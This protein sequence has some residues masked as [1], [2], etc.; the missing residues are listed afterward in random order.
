MLRHGHGWLCIA[1]VLALVG[2]STP[3]H[4][5]SNVR[6]GTTLAAVA[7]CTGGI[8]EVAI[9]ASGGADFL[10]I[11]QFGAF[12]NDGLD[13]SQALERACSAAF[14][15]GRAVLIP[16]GVYEIGRDTA[17]TCTGDLHLTGQG[18]VQLRLDRSL[19]LT[20]DSADDTLVLAGDVAR[21]ALA[22]V[23]DD[24]GRCTPGDLL[25]IDTTV[26]AENAWKTPKREVHRIKSVAGTTLTLEE[27]L[28][29]SY[30]PTDANLAVAVYKKRRLEI[31]N[32]VFDATDH[33]LA[34]HY[35]SGSALRNC[36]WMQRDAG[37][38]TGILYAPR[39]SLDVLVQDATFEG[40]YYGC[41]P[42]CCRNVVFERIQAHGCAGDVIAPSV[43]CYNVAIDDLWGSEC[44]NLIDSH[45]SF[46]VHYNNVS[47]TTTGT[48]NLRSLGGSVRNCHIESTAGKPAPLYLQTVPLQV[49][50]DLYGET[51][52]LLENVTLITPYLSANDPANRAV[53]LFGRRAVLSNVNWWAFDFYPGP[54]GARHGF[55]EIDI[56]DSSLTRLSLWPEQQAT[57]R[58]CRFTSPSPGESPAD[59]ALALSPNASC[60]ADDTTFQGYTH[61][62]SAPGP[63]SAGFTNCRFANCY[64]VFAPSNTAPAVSF[65]DCT[66]RNVSGWGDIDTRN[67]VV[68]NCT[69]AK[70]D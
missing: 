10:D 46:E 39:N 51:T 44:G 52:L 63:R 43:W 57:I 14:S 54:V 48:P 20:A 6:A 36:R 70:D 61:V 21:T 22:L 50:T 60:S 53:V 9:G 66:F 28:V 12:P 11:Q 58:H 64:D 13:D 27:P 17:I 3:A 31:D 23:V 35:F 15:T 59:I 29:F 2:S 56:S 1:V 38:R 7:T 33:L 18:Q 47:G 69:F 42:S 37:S 45:P 41:V 25:F 34:T 19:T 62:L 65:S 55:R 5:L 67:L 8:A 24:A 26:V 30:G 32:V 16:E 68:H 49:D 40:G 4:A